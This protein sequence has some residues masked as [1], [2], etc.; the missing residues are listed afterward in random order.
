ML[1]LVWLSFFYLAIVAIKELKSICEKENKRND[2]LFIK[3]K[4]D[5]LFGNKTTLNQTV[6]SEETLINNKSE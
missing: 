5:I 2:P 1:F 4:N 3:L 6:A